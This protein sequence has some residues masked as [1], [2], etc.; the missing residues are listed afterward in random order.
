MEEINATLTAAVTFISLLSGI[1]S[2]YAVWNARRTKV[3]IAEK[4]SGIVNDLTDQVSKWI[5]AVEKRDKII[6]DRDM[7]IEH[8]KQVI[9][10]KD[11][12]IAQLQDLMN[13]LREEAK[14]YGITLVSKLKDVE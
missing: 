4:Y 2:I 5:D 10:E 13:R 7:T 9:V 3:D 12:L 8:Q 6:A 11:L 14:E 1:G